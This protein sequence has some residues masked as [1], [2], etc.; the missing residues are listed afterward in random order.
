MIDTTTGEAAIAYAAGTERPWHGLGATLHAEATIDEWAVAAKLNWSAERAVVEYQNGTMRTYEDKHVI[1]RSDTQAPLSVVSKDYRIVQPVEALA[2]FDTLSK[3][4]GFHI[5]T[6]GALHEGRRIWALARVGENA[7]VRDDMVAPYLMLATSYD[8]TMA[9]IAQ[10]TTVRVVCNNTLQ[11]SLRSTSGKKTI[12][13]SHSAMFKPVEVKDALGI[14][15]TSWEEFLLKANALAFRQVSMTE[16]DCYLQEVLEPPAHMMGYTSEK[17]RVSKGYRSI[18][19]LFKGG[20]IGAGQ[21]AIDCTA[22]GLLNATTQYIDHHKGRLLDNRV[23]AAWFGPGARLKDKA[24]A[25]ILEL[26]A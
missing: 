12:C 13:I 19:D 20:Q 15:L 24:Y 8:G 2:F 14:D 17:V 4:G 10:F 22:W 5:E 3:Q 25:A 23:D 26:I 1:Y 16:V 7:K 18:L 6:A 21:D 9:T 11:A